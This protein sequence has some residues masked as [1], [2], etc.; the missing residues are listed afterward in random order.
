M[1]TLLT[2]VFKALK[3]LGNNAEQGS[4]SHGTKLPYTGFTLQDGFPQSKDTSG[5]WTQAYLIR[6]DF[7]D[8]DNVRATKASDKAKDFFLKNNIVLDGDECVIDT[9]LSSEA[10]LPDPELL[11]NGKE[12]WHGVLDLIFL[13]GQ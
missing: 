12:V 8:T 10:M 3:V 1:Q 7:W 11:E 9:N 5:E 4:F 2:G 13:T 6:I